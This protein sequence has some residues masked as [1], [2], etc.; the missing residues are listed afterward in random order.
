[1]GSTTCHTT[2]KAASEL[3]KGLAAKKLNGTFRERVLPLVLGALAIAVA[4]YVFLGDGFIS[5]DHSTSGV[6]K[7]LK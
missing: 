5:Q 4:G 3:L 2:P 7:T 1:L 6:E